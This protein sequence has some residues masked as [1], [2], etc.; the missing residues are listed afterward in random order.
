VAEAAFA[1]N[2]FATMLDR[3]E[4]LVADAV[5]RMERGDITPNPSSGEACRYCPVAACPKKGA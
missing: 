5:A 2:T 1:D 3:T 4:A